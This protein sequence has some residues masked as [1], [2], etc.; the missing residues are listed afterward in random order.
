MKILQVGSGL[1]DWGGIERYV[2]YLQAGLRERKHEVLVTCPPD[3]PLSKHSVDPRHIASK[4]KHDL[5]AMSAY[6]RLFREHRFDV[7]HVHFNPDFL[8]AG[9]AARL[10]KQ[11]KTVLTRHVALPWSAAKAKLYGSL[12]DT[13]I[14]V[15]EAVQRKLLCSGIPAEKMIVAKAGCAALISKS[16]IDLGEGFHVGTFGRLVPEKGLPIFFKA[17]AACPTVTGHIYGSGP[18]EEE[19]KAHAPKNAVFHGFVTDVA[20]H[21]AAMDAIVIPSQWE[22]AFPYAALEAMSLGKPLVVSNVGGLPEIVS[23]GVNGF[24]FEK[25]NPAELASKLEQL[26]VDKTA[27][28]EMGRNGKELHRAEYTVQKMAERIE[29]AY[30]LSQET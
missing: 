5:N 21:M 27:T 24:L 19:L 20:E 12:F 13:I 17:L 3:S 6:L 4:G 9:L 7:V 14:P 30:A 29:G 8:V 10:R 28:R 26:A 11:P 15:S 1:F 2:S 16:T 22:E 25:S 23:D 18:M